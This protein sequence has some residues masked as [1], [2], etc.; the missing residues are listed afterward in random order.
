MFETVNQWSLNSVQVKLTKAAMDR[1]ER[2]MAAG[3]CV[4]CEQ[5]IRKGQI[6]RRGQCQTCY[7]AFRKALARKL[8]TEAEAVR[9]GELL[10]VAKGGRKPSNAFTKKLSGRG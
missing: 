9:N 4:A 10:P 6:V 5:A 2:L 3:C 8:V 1:R 7:Y